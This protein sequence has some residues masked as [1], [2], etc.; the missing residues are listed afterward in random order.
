MEEQ[1][2]VDG[3]PTMSLFGCCRAEIAEAAPMGIM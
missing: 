1:M 2:A 3:A